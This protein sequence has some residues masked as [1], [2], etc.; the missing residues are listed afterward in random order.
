IDARTTRD[1]L[2]IVARW[3]GDGRT[4]IAVLHDFEQVR[5]H[6]PETMLIARE[7]IGWGPTA[8]VMSAANLMTARA[9]AERWDED[10]AICEPAA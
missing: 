3:H 10:A 4:V 8:E 2:D 5:A 9:M 7:L 6:F 1:L